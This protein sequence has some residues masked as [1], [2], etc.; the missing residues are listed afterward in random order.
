MDEA[1]IFGG[2]ITSGIN[3]EK[4]DKIPV[5]VSRILFSFFNFFILLN[6]FVWIESGIFRLK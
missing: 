6:Q 1:E 4:Y 2:A 5:N 3:F